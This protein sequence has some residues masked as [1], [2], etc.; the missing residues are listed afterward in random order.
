ML[1]KVKFKTGALKRILWFGLI[2]VTVILTLIFVTGGAITS[3]IPFLLLYACVMPFISLILSKYFIKKANRLQVL[4]TNVRYEDTIEWYRETTY[5]ICN[6]AGM[7]K[8]PDLA[9]YH[10]NDKNA[11]ATGRSKNSS[12]IAVSTALL[13]E[14]SDEAVEAVIAHEVSHIMN[15][16][17]VT[18]TLLQSAL[19]MIVSVIIL[20]ITIFKWFS[21]FSDERNSAAIYYIAAIFEFLASTVL[22]FI[23]GLLLKKYS[24]MREFKADH[25]ASQLTSPQKMIQVLQELDG[26]AVLRQEQKKYAAMQFNGESRFMDLFSTHPSIERRIQYIQKEF[27]LR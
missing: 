16:D 19:N 25:L 12:L 14:M 1:E 2:N 21:F 20:P 24:R 23:S 6:E 4:E 22:F 15:G 17:M 9:I 8:I 11:F 3:L 13:Y 18:Q 26:S 7:T 10:S 5:R 27:G